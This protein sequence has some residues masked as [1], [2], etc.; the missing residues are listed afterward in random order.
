MVRQRSSITREAIL[1][2]ALEAFGEVGFA[3]ASIRDI[4]ARA[5][6]T[7]PTLLYHFPTKADLLLAVLAARDDTDDG[8][9]V[10][11]HALPGDA[12]LRVLVRSARVNATKRGIVELFAQLSAEAS[13][14]QHPARDFFERRYA[15]LRDSLARGVEDLQ[16][17]GLAQA[18]LDP[19]VTASTVI[20]IMDG[21]QVQWLL[22]PNVDMA[23]ALKAYLVRTVVSDARTLD[24]AT[25]P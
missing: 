25:K 22:D 8:H 1:E 19:E 11:F 14:P 6:I 23:A 5:G 15:S 12:K 20:A 4:A 21:L 24:E 16:A 18:G 2:R 7:H 9:H 13:L 3:G 17:R 10:D